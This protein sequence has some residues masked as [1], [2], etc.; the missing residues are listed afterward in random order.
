MLDHERQDQA[1]FDV[2]FTQF[3]LK[4]LRN[5]LP[6]SG[7]QFMRTPLTSMQT[8]HMPLAKVFF[9]MPT[10]Y[11]TMAALAIEGTFNLTSFVRSD[12]HSQSVHGPSFVETH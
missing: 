5:G 10:I 11:R 9:I 1:L 7:A 2:V 8:H 6:T 12:E 4:L 3:R